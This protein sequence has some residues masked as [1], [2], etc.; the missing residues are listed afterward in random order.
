MREYPFNTL[1]FWKTRD[2]IQ[3]RRFVEDYVDGM[4]VKSTYIKSTD[5]ADKEKT[6]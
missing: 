3:L 5:L 1:L 4:N 6:P 2:D